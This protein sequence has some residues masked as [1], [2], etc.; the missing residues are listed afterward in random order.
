ML[1]I[2]FIS[3]WII[4]MITFSWSVV[5]ASKEGAKRLKKL[6]NIPCYQCDFFTGD[7]RLKCTVNPSTACS[8]EALGCIDFEPK[9]R[10]KNNFRRICSKNNQFHISETQLQNIHRQNI[11]EQNI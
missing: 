3:L 1:A 9:R 4:L 6:H 11:H 7:F 5:R 10:S 8:E 2:F